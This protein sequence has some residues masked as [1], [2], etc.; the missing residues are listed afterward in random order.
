[1]VTPESKIDVLN[2][3]LYLLEENSVVDLAQNDPS[4]KEFLKELYTL[5]KTKAQLYEKEI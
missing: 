2:R 1:M 4:F 3:I 5:I